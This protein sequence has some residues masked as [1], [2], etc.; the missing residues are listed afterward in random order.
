MKHLWPTSEF[1]LQQRKALSYSDYQ[2]RLWLTEFYS[3]PSFRSN[4]PRFYSEL[5]DANVGRF[6]VVVGTAFGFSS[7]VYVIMTIFGMF[8]TR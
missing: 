8:G 1:R 3:L 2:H 5:K 4:S 6:R 7:L